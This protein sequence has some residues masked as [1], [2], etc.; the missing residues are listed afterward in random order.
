[1]NLTSINADVFRAINDLGKQFSFMNPIMVFVAEYLLYILALY[2][3]VCWFTRNRGNK[4]MIVSA[5]IAFG[6]AE[7]IGKLAG[8]LHVNYQPFAE[9]DDVNQLVEHA[10]DN[11]FPSDHTILFFSF[12]FTFL[13]FRKKPAVLWVITA[14]LVGLSRIWVGVHYP[15]DVAVGALIGIA[16]AWVASRIAPKL[17]FIHKLLGIY[18]KLEQKIVPVKNR[19]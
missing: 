9:L 5:V 6:L 13:F 3:L 15:G 10:I 19:A 16:S 12:C 17:P 7:L 11:S 8:K 14:I 4:M 1:V 18:E 2:V